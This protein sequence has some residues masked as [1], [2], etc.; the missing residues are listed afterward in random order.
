MKTCVINHDWSSVYLELVFRA[1]NGLSLTCY[2]SPPFHSDGLGSV[3]DRSSNSSFGHQP[4]LFLLLLRGLFRLPTRSQRLQN[5]RQ[6]SRLSGLI[7]PLLNVLGW[8]CLM[9]QFNLFACVHTFISFSKN[10]IFFSLSFAK[11]AQCE[12]NYYRGRR[13]IRC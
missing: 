6:R 10:V 8:Q 5:R 11:Q 4:L 1:T 3:H 13:N 9:H 2:L 7:S 12:D